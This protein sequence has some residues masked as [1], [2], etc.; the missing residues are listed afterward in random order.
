MA[1][2]NAER[3][4]TAREDDPERRGRRAEPRAYVLLP[5]MAEAL[6]GHR[7]VRVVDVSRT[8]AKLEGSSL[9]S[10]GKD[11]LL[12]CAGLDTFGTVVWEEAG[13]CGL[14]FDEPISLR[15]LARLRDVAFAIERSD[16]TADE[17]EAAADW[18]N[19]L[20]R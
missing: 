20:A 13:R 5:A 1:A 10:V 18:T 12:V 4:K 9:P 14:A 8:G 17:I 2:K 7:H 19:G 11:I 15:D 6:S 3:R 16:L